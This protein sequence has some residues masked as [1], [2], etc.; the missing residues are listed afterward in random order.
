MAKPVIIELVGA[1]LCKFR[2][3]ISAVPLSTPEFFVSIEKNGLT[4][5]Y[6]ADFAN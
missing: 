5:Q 3:L 6:L 2:I 4:F 1:P